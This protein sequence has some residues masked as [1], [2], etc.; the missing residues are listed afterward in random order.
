MRLAGGKAI[1]NCLR[2]NRDY[3]DNLAGWKK[4]RSRYML[5]P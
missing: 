5:Y 1:P 2:E 4:L 3:E